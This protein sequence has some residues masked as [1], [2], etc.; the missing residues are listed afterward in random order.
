MLPYGSID[1]LTRSISLP[2][3]GATAPDSGFGATA[4]DE[5]SFFCGGD[6][7]GVGGASPCFFESKDP[8]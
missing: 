1:S 5:G 2:G 8:I 6:G 3:T 7:G 4:S